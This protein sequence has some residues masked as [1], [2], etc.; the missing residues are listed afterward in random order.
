M[1][2][3]VFGTDAIKYLIGLWMGRVA[4]GAVSGNPDGGNDTDVSHQMRKV[5]V[6][7]ENERRLRRLVERAEERIEKMRQAMSR[8][9]GTRNA[10]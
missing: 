3:P 8:L 7:W 9:P 5:S 1:N 2:G 10:T 4:I 6:L